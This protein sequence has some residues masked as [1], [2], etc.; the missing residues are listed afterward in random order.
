MSGPITRVLVTGGAGFIG[1]NFVRSVRR[2]RPAWHVVNYDA[3]T[4][5]GNLASLADLE[6]DPRHTFIHADVRDAGALR[7]ALRGCQA[8]VHLAAESHVDRSIGDSAPFVSTNVLGTQTLLEECRRLGDLVCFVQVSTDEVY[9]S[10]ELD[11]PDLRFSESSALRPR[12]P[13]AASKA[14]ADLLAL[15]CHHTYGLPVVVTRSS[16]NYGPY[17]YPEKVIPLFVTNLLDGRRVPLYGDGLNVRDW[18]HVEDHC[19]ALLAAL[20]RGRAGEVYNIGADN[21]RSN[22]ELTRAILALMGAGEE[23]IE[24][25]ADRPG[26]DRR[27]AIDSAKIRA[28]L[29]WAPKRSWRDGLA[30]TIAWYRASEPWWRPLKANAFNATMLP[31]ALLSGTGGMGK[32]A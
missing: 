13:Y 16:N 20:E 31:S 17:Q 27:Y 4:Y 6:G 1:S 25:V 5:A 22:Q 18:I 8:V 30:E 11:R 10:L 28:E 14:A 21:E 3:L 29:G 19:E 2:R 23:M 15:A 32:R 12:S 26:H 9:G 7:S 24:P